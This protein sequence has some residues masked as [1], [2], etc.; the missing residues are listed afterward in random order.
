MSGAVVEEYAIFTFMRQL[1]K[2]C[3]LAGSNVIDWTGSS[4]HLQLEPEA[5]DWYANN[6]ANDGRF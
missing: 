3:V 2:A 5:L 1:R 4:A 6:A